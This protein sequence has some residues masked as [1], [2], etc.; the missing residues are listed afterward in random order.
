MSVPFDRCPEYVSV[1]PLRDAVHAAECIAAALDR[2]AG[3]DQREA[4]VR[5]GGA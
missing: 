3:P 5:E 2:S 4:L 1:P